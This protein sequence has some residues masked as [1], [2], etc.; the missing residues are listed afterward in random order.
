MAAGDTVVSI[1]ENPTAA[2]TKTALDAAIT[3]TSAA[4]RVTVTALGMGKSIMITAIEV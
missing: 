2:T 4:A 1:V 3:A